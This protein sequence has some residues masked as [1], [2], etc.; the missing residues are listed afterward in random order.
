MATI[1]LTDATWLELEA[2]KVLG[3]LKS[4]R[5]LGGADG[6]AGKDVADLVAML[7][8]HGLNYTGAQLAAIRIKLVG[9]EVIEIV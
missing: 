6:Q 7:S 5:A 2:S 8:Y 1:K 9:D 4:N 3:V